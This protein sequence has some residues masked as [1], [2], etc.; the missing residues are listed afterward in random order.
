MHTLE[1]AAEGHK[2][3]D[4]CAPGKA[5]VHHDERNMVRYTRRRTGEGGG[6]DERKEGEGVFARDGEQTANEVQ[7]KEKGGL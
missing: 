5:A 3:S 2:R 7:A 1:L 4:T 6:E